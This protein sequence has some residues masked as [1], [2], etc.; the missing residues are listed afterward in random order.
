[1]HIC[2]NLLYHLFQSP[3]L[4]I[5]VVLVILIMYFIKCYINNW[6]EYKKSKYSWKQ[7]NTFKSFIKEK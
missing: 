2:P 3:D 6:N 7:L 1:M 4:F 5:L